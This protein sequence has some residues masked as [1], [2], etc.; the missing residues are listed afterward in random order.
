MSQLASFYVLPA[1]RLDDLMEAA[2]P[3]QI[4][5]KVRLLGVIPCTT[6]EQKDA[7]W[8]FLKAHARE[9]GEPDSGSVYCELD[10]FL[11]EKHTMLF[12]LA[13]KGT[14]DQLS[15]AR[16]SSN[17]V[18]DYAAAQKATAMLGEVDFGEEAIRNYCAT[19][20]SAFSAEELIEALQ[21][22]APRARAWMDE[23]GRSDLGI[24]MIG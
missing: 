19:G 3:K 6:T 1:D 7:Y 11:E 17:A 8:E 15:R 24:L 20:G 4:T 2:I 22:A 16:G 14:S 5:R 21:A 12:D 10:L 23:V 13:L 18:F 9:C